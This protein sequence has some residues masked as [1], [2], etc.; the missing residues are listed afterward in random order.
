MFIHDSLSELVVCGETEMTAAELRTKMYELETKVATGVTGYQMQFQ[1]M[2]SERMIVHVFIIMCV[3]LSGQ[4]LEMVS[5]QYEAT[6]QEAEAHCNDSKNRF[7]DKLPSEYVFFLRLTQCVHN[8]PNSRKII[9]HSLSKYLLSLIHTL[10]GVMC[11][12]VSHRAST[13]QSL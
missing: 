7:P 10:Q 6:Y 2:F 8:P 3:V 11:V 5:G 4:T 12:Y 9:N 1:V 13:T